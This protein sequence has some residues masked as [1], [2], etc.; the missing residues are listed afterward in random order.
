MSASSL[1][2]R[3][4]RAQLPG[5]LYWGIFSQ[6]LENIHHPAS[7][8]N[9]VVS[10]C[11][12]ENCL[13]GSLIAEK[14][15]ATTSSS[16]S[17]PGQLCY[18][19][20][21]GRQGLRKTFSALAERRITGGSK[22]DFTKLSI[23]GGCGALIQ[24]LAF[25]LL[26]PG[27][28]VILVTPT[29]GMLYNDF[30]V[31]AGVSVVDIPIEPGS[32]ILPSDLTAAYNRAITQGLRPKMLFLLNPD[33][34]LGTIRS[35]DEIQVILIWVDAQGPDFHIVSD[36]IYALSVYDEDKTFT[37]VAQIRRDNA[38][39]DETNDLYLG[40]NTHILWGASKDFCASGLRMGVLFSHNSAL[41]SALS[42]V[43]YF[44]AACNSMQ[45]AFAVALSD[46]PWVD[47]FV[48]ENHRRLREARDLVC[49]F[50]DKAGVP[51]IRPSAGLF[52]WMD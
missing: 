40:N 17:I 21:R 41:L 48:A 4:S 31:L 9:G 10:F 12:A 8:P 39:S 28:A 33:N 37:S 50:L 2:H 16:W 27:D 18:G 36:E 6:A 11:V 25:L 51:Y 5:L 43:G 45:D 3:S 38:G 47:F 20:M 29:Y 22:V 7:N 52:I 42:N 49:Y 13:S 23:G 46:V 26:D 32:P 1:S 35:N 34:P 44:S 24:H 15:H 30:G 14:L 19:D